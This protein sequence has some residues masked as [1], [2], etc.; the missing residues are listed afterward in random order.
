MVTGSGDIGLGLAGLPGFVLRGSAGVA[1]RARV[2][3]VGSR[4]RLW[5]MDKA[6]KDAVQLARDGG[7]DYDPTLEPW[8]DGF[9]TG[10]IIR[11]V[12]NGPQSP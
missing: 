11:P 2:D 12:K 1:P 7:Y 5:R 8:R 3:V 4:P 10:D 6:R 9:S